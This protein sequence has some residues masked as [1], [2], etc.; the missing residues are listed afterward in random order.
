MTHGIDIGYIPTGCADREH[1]RAPLVIGHGACDVRSVAA[2]DTNA[3]MNVGHRSP[4]KVDEAEP[5]GY[6]RLEFELD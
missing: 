3:E 5:R 1:R 2:S 6:D 4:E